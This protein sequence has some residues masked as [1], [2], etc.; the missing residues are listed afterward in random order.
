LST[1]KQHRR[2][3][4]IIATVLFLT[5]S[6]HAQQSNTFYLLHELPQSNQ[7]NPAVQISCKWFIGI[8]ALSSTQTSYNNTAFSYKDL[9]G[10]DSW[11]LEGVE[12]Q[13]HRTDLYGTGLSLQVLA[14][15][16]RHKSN[17]FTFNINERAHLYQLVPGELATVAI[18]GNGAMIGEG[19][20]FDALRTA[21][22]YLR[23]YA[24]GV[25]RVI[26]RSWTAGIRVKML[27]GKAGI[28]S[29]QSDLMLHT[30][31]SKFDLL[32]EADY[33]LNSSFPVT[34]EQDADGLITGISY[35]EPDLLPFLMN[36]SN[37]GFA[38]DLG[39]VHRFNSRIS[40]SAS[41]LD[42]GMVRW[43][44][45]LNNIDA[46]GSFIYEGNETGLGGGTSS[47][48]REIVDSLY[49]SFD[50]EVSTEAFSTLL[51]MQLY[52]GG[53]YRFN[54]MLS[55]GLVN[56]NMLFR[57]KLYSSITISA[58]A[59]LKDRFLAT[60]SWSLMNKS[61][62]N[63]GAGIAW[64]GNGL[65]FHLVSDNVLGFFYPFDTRTLNLRL[66]VN[67]LLG[68]PRNKKEKL[69][70]ASYAGMPAGGDCSWSSKQK[71]RE[72]RYRKT[73]GN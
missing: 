8:P 40:L 24:F 19:A 65:Q 34:V 13:M 4:F 54:D 16:Y 21:G 39:I 1:L 73:R 12:E 46:S 10:D 45:D 35:N 38:I 60:L 14:L 72:K 53:S 27:F 7:L 37:P 26:D 47:F 32:A 62:R 23:E 71:S 51:P 3:L 48:F 55:A 57:S 69:Q 43:T 29:G 2:H 20:R 25:S 66:G 11:N 18:H 68:C 17:Y 9:A 44:T 36:R 67:L 30:D 63:L 59:D 31:E 6:T 61:A 33:G 56:H 58:T 15:G 42:I 52:L 49:N 28:A 50:Y 22:T 41:L 64:H 5:L 70:S